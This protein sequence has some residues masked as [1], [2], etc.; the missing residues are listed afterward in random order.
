MASTDDSGIIREIL[1]G[2]RDLYAHLVRKYQE[3]V[4][5]LCASL[6]SDTTRAEDAAQ[7]IFIKAFQSL[8]DFRGASSFSTWLYRIAAHHCTDI[9]R[10]ESRRRSESWESLVERE[11][12]RI[13]NLLI[14]P[15]AEG[16]LNES[17]DLIQRILDQIPEDYRVILTLREVQGLSYAEISETLN[18][19]LDAV[20]SRLRRARESL[21]EKMRHFSASSN[22]KG[23][24]RFK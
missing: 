4:L 8:E 6:L 2:E 20:K 5:R 10:K 19:S 11:G 13:H 15:P 23:Y 18:C 9:L 22:V 3:K 14:A 12:E 16:E 17:R 21:E 1:S 7:E 24:R